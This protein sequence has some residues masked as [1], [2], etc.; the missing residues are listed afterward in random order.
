MSPKDGKT[1]LLEGHKFHCR[2]KVQISLVVN[3]TPVTHPSKACKGRR[4][5]R[6]E[7]TLARQCP[8]SSP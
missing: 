2:V 5:R 6:K 3:N 4:L 1:L 8:P 7:L